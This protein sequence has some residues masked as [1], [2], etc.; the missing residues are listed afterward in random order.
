MSKDKVGISDLFAFVLHNTPIP[1]LPYVDE[2]ETS[3]QA[4]DLIEP[5]ASALLG[6]VLAFLRNKGEY[7]ATD[8]EMQD[9]MPI[10]PS[11]QRPRR[12]DLVNRG[13]VMDSG[14]TRKTKAGRNA[15]VWVAI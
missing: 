15:V 3:K 5:K 2:S 6:K 4:A 1:Y 12:I 7:G 14:L 9:Q 13:L 10:P 8:E 11:T